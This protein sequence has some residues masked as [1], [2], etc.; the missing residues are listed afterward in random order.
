MVPGQAHAEPCRFLGLAAGAV[1]GQAHV[2][3]QVCLRLGG[4]LGGAVGGQEIPQFVDGALAAQ[5]G[6]CARLDRPQL[7][8]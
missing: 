3:E 2:E 7:A 6:Q 1:V 4:D 8:R 5:Q